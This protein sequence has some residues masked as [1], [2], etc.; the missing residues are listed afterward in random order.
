MEEL[1]IFDGITQAEI[2]RMI[3]CF[4]AKKV[5][6]PKGHTL[7]TYETSLQ[8]LGIL[9]SGKAHLY[10]I[11]YDG[12]YTLLEQFG[13]NGLF[14]E[15]FALPLKDWEYIVE[16]D[17]DCEVLFLPY[18]SIIKRCPNACDH[19]SKLIDN[20]FHLAT[21]KSQALSLRINLLSTKTLRQKLMNYLNWQQHQAGTRTFRINMSLTALADYLCVD[22]SSLMRELRAMKDEGILESK[23]R[24]VTMMEL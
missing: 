18:E 23:G 1:N 22:R 20:L 24:M 2:N 9:L 21:L 14:G 3:P 10:C 4:E 11:D 7:M 16:A 6:F 12:T 8:K 5:T 15:L 17:T 13:K 19:H